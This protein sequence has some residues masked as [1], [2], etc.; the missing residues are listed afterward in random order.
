MGGSILGIMNFY[1]K[2]YPNLDWYKSCY[3][4]FMDAHLNNGTNIE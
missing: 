4:N 2:F 3:K 1:S